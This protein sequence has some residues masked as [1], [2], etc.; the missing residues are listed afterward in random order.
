MLDGKS[1]KVTIRE[2]ISYCEPNSDPV[3]FVASID[4]MIAE[5]PDGEEGSSI[6]KLIV[7]DGF[8]TTQAASN[9]DDIVKYWND[10]LDHFTQF[11][12]YM[13]KQ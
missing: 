10:N 5:E 3:S 1:H 12:E 6:D 7:Y 4:A 2:C 13:S 9:Y 11:A 8:C